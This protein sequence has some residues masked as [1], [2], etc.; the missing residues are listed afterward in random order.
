MELSNTP[1]IGIFS[2]NR[3]VT[4]LKN[5]R[6]S[7]KIKEIVEANEVAQTTI[8]FFSAS[9]VNL[10]TNKIMGMYYNKKEWEQK[11]FPFPDV[12]YNRVAKGLDVPKYIKIRDAFQRQGVKFINASSNFDKWE[13]YRIIFNNGD[14]KKHLPYTKLFK[15]P[16][17][18]K[19][20]FQT[21]D[22][23]YLKT[24]DG[25]RGKQIM[26]VQR[27]CNDY[28]YRYIFQNNVVINKVKQFNDLCE[29]ISDFFGEQKII[30]QHAIDSHMISGR[31][32]DMRC[33]VQ[34]NGKGEIE[35]IGTAVRLGDTSSPVSYTKQSI[36][37]PFS[38]FLSDQLHYRKEECEK[39]EAKVK[40]FIF[41][42]YKT[43]ESAYGSF[44]EMGIDFSIDKKGKIWFIE[45]N[46]TSGKTS[47][48]K[49]FGDS[50]VRKSYLNRLEYAKYIMDS[51]RS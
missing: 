37:Y 50:I 31:L 47:L 33:E 42:V 44:G 24:T 38:T 11:E 46:A 14:L 10:H 5:Q 23:I 3:D 19:T 49:A 40:R 48:R 4:R 12:L 2:K 25:R 34:R 15:K 9:D 16:N 39:M 27:S 8:Y 30:M 6:M 43:I 22:T 26:R 1:V 28:E 41:T 45:C 29:V 51:D 13:V 7:F 20:M 32:A 36:Y 21:S 17:N 18:L 35:I